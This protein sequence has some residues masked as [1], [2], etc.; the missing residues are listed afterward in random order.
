[1]IVLTCADTFE[2]KMCCIY[3]A[4]VYALKIGHENVRLRTEPI[5]QPTLF[6]EYIHVDYEE[7]KFQKVVRT[8]KRKLSVPIYIDIYYVALSKEE[9]ALDTIYRYLYAGFPIGAAIQTCYTRPEV[10]RMMELRRNVGN[11][12]H[13]FREFVRF[14]SLDNHYYIAHIEPKNNVALPVANYFVDRMPSEHFMIIDDN[15]GYGVI[16][17]KDGELYI[18]HFSKE[19][20]QQFAQMEQTEDEYTFMWRDF[21]RA[22]SIEQRQNPTCQ[23]NLFP[24][25]MRKHVTEFMDE[26]QS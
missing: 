1:M 25:W 26:V 11:E 8:I 22:I 14:V 17:P 20:L 23:R 2:D 19:E 24:K 6:D 21:F 12:S 4:W 10:M 16:H 13:Y 18:K 5:I 3:D 15:R 7:E 9:D